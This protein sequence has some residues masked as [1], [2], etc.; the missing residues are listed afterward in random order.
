MQRYTSYILLIIC[1]AIKLSMF[2]CMDTQVYESTF[3]KLMSY[4]QY[5]YIHTCSICLLIVSVNRVI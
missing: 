1:I 4:R 3:R 2:T 5:R